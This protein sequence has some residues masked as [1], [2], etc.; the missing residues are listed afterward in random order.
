M[1]PE[2]DYSNLEMLLDTWGQNFIDLRYPYEKYEGL[3]QAEY[4]AR[5]DAWLSGGA[6]ESEAD[7]VYYPTELHGLT[8]ALQ[9]EV[10]AWLGGRSA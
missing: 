4:R 8:H 10:D 1:G 7:F 5:S 3:T 9:T 2:A 6:N